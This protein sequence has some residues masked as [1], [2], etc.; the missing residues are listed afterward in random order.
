[1]FQT[2]FNPANLLIIKNI[3]LIQHVKVRPLEYTI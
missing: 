1:M 2:A 3:L